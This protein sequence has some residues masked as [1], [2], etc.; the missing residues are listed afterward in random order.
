MF[1]DVGAMASGRYPGLDNEELVEL[2]YYF[3]MAPEEPVVVADLGQGYLDYGAIANGNRV[4]QD[5][6]GGGRILYNV[7]GV[8]VPQH[9]VDIAQPPYWNN[10]YYWDHNY[11]GGGP[12]AGSGGI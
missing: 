6:G 11:F 7:D 3:G 5:Q 4:D 1:Y 2:G 12:G 10:G 8:V 9:M